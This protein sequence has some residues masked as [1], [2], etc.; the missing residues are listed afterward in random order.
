MRGKM[1]VVLAAAGVLITGCGGSTETSS[2]PKSESKSATADPNEKYNQTW[3]KPYDQ[4]TCAEFTK[5]MNRQQAW[6]MAADMLTSARN[7][8]KDTGLP[9]DALVDEYL[10]G[11]I[12]VCVG[13]KLNMNMA[14]VGT[15]LYMTEPRFQP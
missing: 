7:L 2:S 14:D 11:L 13:D 3:P 8:N 15:G 4:T 5:D 10:A 6:A 1:I 9:S 12:N